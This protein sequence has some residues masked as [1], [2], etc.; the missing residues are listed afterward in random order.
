MKFYNSI[1]ELQADQNCDL[2]ETFCINFNK[3]PK[4]PIKTNTTRSI[5]QHYLDDLVFITQQANNEILKNENGITNY[6]NFIIKCQKQYNTLKR[7]REE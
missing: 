1:E 5:S 2:D 6:S 3:Y 7:K 4:S